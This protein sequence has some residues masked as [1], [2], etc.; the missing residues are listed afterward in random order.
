LTAINNVAKL[1][2]QAIVKQAN[3][4]FAK[5]WRGAITDTSEAELTPN[6]GLQDRDK[7]YNALIAAINCDSGHGGYRYCDG[8]RAG[9]KCSSE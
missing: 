8:R 5:T 3:H 4:T 7:F 6:C 2:A 9:K 1:A